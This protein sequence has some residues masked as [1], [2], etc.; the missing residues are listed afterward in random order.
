MAVSG[1]ASWKISIN[2]WK[3]A[4][5]MKLAV[6]I[7]AAS[8]HSVEV[9]RIMKYRV[10]DFLCNC[11]QC[12]SEY[13]RQHQ[14]RHLK[15]CPF[16]TND[17][18]FKVVGCT[19][20]VLNRD[21]Q[22]H[23]KEALSD[24]FSLVAKQSCDVEAQ[25]RKTGLM[26]REQNDK[27]MTRKNEVTDLNNEE[28]IAQERIIELQ[29]A[30]KEATMEC[31]ELKRK[32]AMIKEKVDNEISQRDVSLDQFKSSLTRLTTESKVRSMLRS[33]TSPPSS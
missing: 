15:V 18:P 30:I 19:R 10:R 25:V 7:T 22:E 5:F 13:E 3:I 9:Y 32:H 31:E 27:L 26:F 6:D 20:Q 14:D 16:T 29:K 23:F 8:Q 4:L 21:L 1:L 24:H 2:T 28:K 12:G 33:G 11:R 17:C